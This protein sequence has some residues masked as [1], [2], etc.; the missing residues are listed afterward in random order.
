MEPT[1]LLVDNASEPPIA[2]ALHRSP[3]PK[4][5]R[6]VHLRQPSNGGGSGGFNAGIAAALRGASDTDLIWLLD[7][8]AEPER[9]ALLRLIE[10]LVLPDVVMAGSTLIDPHTREPFECGGFID[11][12]SGEYVQR[13]PDGPEPLACDYLAACSILTTAGVARAAGLFPETFLNG[14]DVGWGCRVRRANRGRLVGVPASRVAH[15]R[16]DRMRAAARYFAARGAM[17]ALAEAGVPVFGRAMR[18]AA[19]AASL[20]ATGL[21]SLAELHLR[22]LSD[23]V[24]GRVMGPLPAGVD[25]ANPDR[26]GL[27][28]EQAEG[29]VSG[30]ARVVSARGRRADWFNAQGSLAVDAQG[31]WTISTGRA[32]QALR[33]ASALVR[34]LGLAVRLQKTKGAFGHAPPAPPATNVRGAD[35][36]LSIVIVAYNRKDALLRTMAHLKATEPAASAEIIVVDNASAD[37]TT[38]ALRASH[39]DV[40]VLELTENTGVSAF[41]RG[42]EAATGKTILI[43]DDDSWPDASG[44]ALALQLLADRQ[45]VVGV[46][47]HPRHPDGGRSEWPF[48][49]RVFTAS[50]AWPIMGC[51]NLVRKGAWQRAGG[52]CEGYFLYRNDTDLAISLGSM[53]SVWFDPTWVVWHDSPA[54]TRKSIRWCHLATRNWLWMARR[55]GRGSDRLFAL[56]GIAQAVRLAGARPRALR[57]VIRGVF[58]GLTNGPPSTVARNPAGWKALMHLRLGRPVPSACRYLG[59]CTKP[60]TQQPRTPPS[61]LATSSSETSPTASST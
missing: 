15:P 22:G 5:W 41:N 18:E 4:L 58:D 35:N 48:A 12:V 23:A 25:P 42:V 6:L 46:A 26:P 38:E 7:S 55:H 30:K 52:Y 17:V 11:R 14:D 34:G 61:T 57:A 36:G 33:A 49:R 3:L 28:R 24:A 21:H 10:A 29:E 2:E 31:G 40:Q 27:T 19:R 43:L 50:D 45:D 37:G 20:H 60:Q 16:P 32:T 13:P 59:P 51:G 39:P 56:L 8:D 54:A 1:L 53:G 9:D 47:L 44:L